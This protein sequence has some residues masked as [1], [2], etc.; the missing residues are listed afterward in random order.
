MASLHKDPR[1]KSP[2]WYCAFYGADGRRKFK[3]TKTTERKSALAICV[4]WEQSAGKARAGSLTAAQARKV[5]A[6][7]VMVS[8]GEELTSYTVESW[9]TEWLV[10]KAASAS[11]NTMLRYRQVVRDFLE[12]MGSRSKASLAGVTPGDIARYRDAL[13]KGGRAVSTCNMVVKK[14]LSVP[15]ESA[16]RLGYI[17]T[18]P[19]A[20]VDI[21]KSTSEERESGREPFTQEEVSN[22]LAQA[23]GDW[24]GAIILAAT[25]GLRLGDIANLTWNS[26][27]VEAGLLSVETTKTGTTVTL[28]IHADFAGWLAERTGGI[29]KAP[30]FASLASS[31][32]GGRH[33]LSTQFRRIMI[34]AGVEGRVV[35][36]EGKGRTG[37]SKGFHALRHTFISNLANAGVPPEIRQKLAGHSDPKV[38]ARYTHHEIDTLRRAVEKLPSISPG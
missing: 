29:K 30:V 5:L 12:S 34:A 11:D 37:H 8:S 13:R 31:R 32:I 38:H 26:V 2:F 10:N 17:L 27:D 14:I 33:G 20:G 22:L 16:R 1:G 15:F 24:R 23:D 25:T 18:N 36:R 28:P 21:L 7:M 4:A 19:V 9:L 6:E 3:S 35:E